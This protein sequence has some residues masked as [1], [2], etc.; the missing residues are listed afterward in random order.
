MGSD[1]RPPGNASRLDHTRRS[2]TRRP[3]SQ[4]QYIDEPQPWINT[5]HAAQQIISHQPTE[6][7]AHA[8]TNRQ[9]YSSSRA[10]CG[11][12]FVRQIDRQIDNV[13]S[14]LTANH[15]CRDVIIYQANRHTL[16]FILLTNLVVQMELSV[17]SVCISQRSGNIIYTRSLYHSLRPVSNFSR[18]PKSQT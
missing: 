10:V 4:S 16:L 15:H 2:H 13:E 3:S 9:L 17:C 12:Y 11:D 5:A 7:A 8:I 14:A 1:N 6:A 18:R